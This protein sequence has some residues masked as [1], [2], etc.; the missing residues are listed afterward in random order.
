MLRLVCFFALAAA[1]ASVLGHVPVIGPVFQE[2]GI[3]GI[4][5]SAALISA[6]VTRVGERLFTARRLRSDLRALAAVDSPHNHGKIGSVY[7]A[8]GRPRPALPHLERATAGEP[9]VADWHFKLGVAR[10]RTRDREGA[11]KS[12]ERCVE[13]DE[14]HAYGGAQMRR[15][16]TLFELRRNDEAL[17]VLDVVEKNHGPSPESAF[18]RGRVLGSLGRK[19]EA[20]AAFAE[21]V[22]LAR[23]APRYQRKAAAWWSL[24]A[25]I[26]RLG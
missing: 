22:D 18:W 19:A 4:L 10:L 23:R 9:D 17:A 8:R 6:V 14:E 13:I 7:V 5:L 26:A 2:T 24:R 21:V 1:V 12:L 15:A 25:H 3:F 11:L 16:E 20:R